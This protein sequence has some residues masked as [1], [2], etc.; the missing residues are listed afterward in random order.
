MQRAVLLG[1]TGIQVLS[2]IQGDAAGH[3]TEIEVTWNYGLTVAGVVVRCLTL[4]AASMQL[5]DFVWEKGWS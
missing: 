3:M 5:M 4:A 1:F 2:Q